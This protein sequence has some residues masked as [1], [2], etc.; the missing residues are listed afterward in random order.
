MNNISISLL[1]GIAASM[2]LNGCGSNTVWINPHIPPKTSAIKYKKDDGYCTSVSYGTV[3]MPNII[4]NK[5]Y[6]DRSKYGNFNLTNNQTGQ[7]YS[8]TYRSSGGFA[9]AFNEAYAKSRANAARREAKEA[10]EKIWESCM[11]RFGWL[12]ETE[13]LEIIGKSKQNIN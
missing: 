9:S 8:G 10:R 2:I 6:V 5:N 13:F 4:Y 11:Y 3:P 1:S 12:T 7:T